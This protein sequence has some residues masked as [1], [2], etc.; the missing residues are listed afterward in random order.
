MAKRR[1]GRRKSKVKPA[2]LPLAGVA[3]GVGGAGYTI[4]KN[5]QG[6][7]DPGKQVIEFMTGYEVDT[8]TWDWRGPTMLYGPIVGGA[9][10]HKVVKML[11]VNR[12]LAA[13]KLPFRL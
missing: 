6:G 9:I 5:V 8:K 4:Y 13:A 12:T 2:I 3:A 7:A 10:A 1:K 11:G